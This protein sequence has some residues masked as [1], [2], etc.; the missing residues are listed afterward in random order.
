[1]CFC[2]AEPDAVVGRGFS[3]LRNAWFKTTSERC[4]RQALGIENGRLENGEPFSPRAAGRF[5][6]HPP[7]P[8]AGG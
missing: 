4:Q 5:R 2:C 7:E 3:A 1:M 6:R 8:A